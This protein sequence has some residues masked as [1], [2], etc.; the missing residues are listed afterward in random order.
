MKYIPREQWTKEHL[1][2][3]R[4]DGRWHCAVPRDDIATRNGFGWREYGLVGRGSTKQ[5]AI[6]DW[7]CSKRASDFVAD[8]Y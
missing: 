5:K 8:I 2:F 3:W 1:R 7:E 6:E 4:V